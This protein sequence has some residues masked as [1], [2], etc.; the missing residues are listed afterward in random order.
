MGGIIKPND[1]EC[2]LDSSGLYTHSSIQDYPSISQINMKVK[3]NAINVI[4]AVTES[5]IDVY[6][7]LEEHIEGSSSG[8]LSGD[9]AN[10]VDLVKEQYEVR[11]K[12]R[13]KSS[14]YL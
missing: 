10:I 11:F 5:Q 8:K 12:W 9:S 2:H 1:G 6:R 14:I 13:T 7:K 3:Q 4:F